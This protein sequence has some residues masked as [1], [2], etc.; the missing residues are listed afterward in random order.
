MWEFL[1]NFN[2][3]TICLISF[4]LGLMLGLPFIYYVARGGNYLI[5]VPL[6]LITIIILL[7]HDDYSTLTDLQ[8]ACHFWFFSLAYLF[9][10]LI[11]MAIP[12]Q[13]LS[14]RS[15]FGPRQPILDEEK[16]LEDNDEE[17]PQKTYPVIF[18]KPRTTKRTHGHVWERVDNTDDD[19]K[20]Q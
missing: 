2:L 7:R 16:A 3:Y 4:I 10:L 17:R 13:G 18:L 5:A 15:V 20:D 14:E 12:H 19:I 9:D 11:I 1:N 6:S 8:I